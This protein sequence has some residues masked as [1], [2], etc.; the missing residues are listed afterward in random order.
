MRLTFVNSNFTTESETVI[1]PSSIPLKNYKTTELDNNNKNIL[2]NT[3]K[4]EHY[5]MDKL[6]GQ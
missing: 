3:F 2:E 5:Q 1:F 4:T 6:K